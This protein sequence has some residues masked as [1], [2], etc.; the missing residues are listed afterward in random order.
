MHEPRLGIG[1]RSPSR[2]FTHDFKSLMNAS[3]YR[4]ETVTHHNAL[5][6][7]LRQIHRHRISR[8]S[9]PFMRS[10]SCRSYRFHL[11]SGLS[12]SIHAN[13]GMSEPSFHSV[14]SSICSISPDRYFATSLRSLLHPSIPVE[15]QTQEHVVLQQYLCARTGEV[16]CESRHFA[17]EI[18]HLENKAF[19][20]SAV[21]RHTTHPNRG[22][23]DRTCDRRC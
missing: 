21:S 10:R 23:P 18:T 15:S 1:E 7:H 11:R 3:A 6:G 14:K 2:Y 22:R 16:Q 9:H 20:Q 12:L 8:T 13:T 19:R 17:A 4:A 5:H